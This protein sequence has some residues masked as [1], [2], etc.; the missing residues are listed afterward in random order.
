M[1][2]EVMIALIGVGAT[3]AGTI[4]GWL[5][6]NFSNKGKLYIYV[7]SWKDEFKHRSTLGEF[8][9]CTKKEECESYSYKVSF[10]LYNSSGNTKIMRNIRLIFS[11]G[12]KDIKIKVPY[13]EATK[14]YSHSLV[15]YDKVVPINIPPK[16]VIKLELH[17]SFW[18]QDGGTDFI[19][20]TRKVYLEYTNEK[21]KVKRKLIKTENYAGYF[22]NPR[23]EETDNG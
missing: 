12:K 6:N 17:N 3:L 18:H 16:V 20:N 19:W 14:K 22:D 15:Y 21:N 23:P 7:S 13:D 1:T 10:D 9:P 2:D 4:L 11:D 5:L 8:I